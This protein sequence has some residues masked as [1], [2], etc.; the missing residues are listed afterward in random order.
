MANSII[1]FKLKLKEI[2][3]FEYSPDIMYY[4]NSIVLLN[5]G[6]YRSNIDNNLDN[7]PI[8]SGC[9]DQIIL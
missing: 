5:G 4:S 8:Y 2:N 7:H 6:I 3:L 1:I 9:W